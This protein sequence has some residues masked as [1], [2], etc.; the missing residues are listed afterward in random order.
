MGEKGGACRVLVGKP[1][2]QRPLE[3]PRYR[4]EYN[5]KTDHHRV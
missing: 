1:E 3:I 5:I 2:G 4:W